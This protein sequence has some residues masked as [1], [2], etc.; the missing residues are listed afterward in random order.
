MYIHYTTSDLS[1][2]IRVPIFFMESAIWRTHEYAQRGQ[3]KS[4]HLDVSF[5]GEV[6]E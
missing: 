4:V 2:Y 3:F 6:L 1:G 5:V